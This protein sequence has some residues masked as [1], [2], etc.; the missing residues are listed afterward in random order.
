MSGKKKTEKLKLERVGP[1]EWIFVYPDRC[2]LDQ[3]FYDAMELMPEDPEKAEQ[4]FHAILRKFPEHIDAMHHLA[5]LE[6]INGRDDEAFRLAKKAVESGRLCLPQGF[7]AG[8]DRL[9]WGFLENRPFLRACH[10]LGLILLERDSVEEALSIF[11]E[12]LALNPN[13]NQGI[14]DLAIDCNFMLNRP[15]AVLGVCDRYPD[16]GMPGTLYSRPL[17]LFQ[18]GREREAERAL[19]DAIK[20]LPLIAKELVK[21]K[22]KRPQSTMEGYIMRGGEDEAYNYWESS[23][24][25]WEDTPGAVKLVKDLL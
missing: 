3:R 13:D 8:K 18:L 7:S 15:E 23:R 20:R 14:R 11:D 5:I 2:N 25:F 1:H 21:K 10:T 24:T 9:E 22:H 12:L 4:S 6:Q 19:K 17:A 16:D